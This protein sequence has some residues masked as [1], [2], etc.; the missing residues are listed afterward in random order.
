M[1][2]CNI[3]LLWQHYYRYCRMLC[4]LILGFEDVSAVMLVMFS[5]QIH[6]HIFFFRYLGVVRMEFLNE[7]NAISYEVDND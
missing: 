1:E 4:I 5:G 6:L 3:M 2:Y 7:L